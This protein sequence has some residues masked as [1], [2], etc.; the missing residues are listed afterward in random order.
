[1]YIPFLHH[2]CT[3]Y[4]SSRTRVQE[5]VVVV[6][7]RRVRQFEARTNM[8]VRTDVQSTKPHFKLQ[9]LCCVCIDRANLAKSMRNKRA[10]ARYIIQQPSY[11]HTLL[12]YYELVVLYSHPVRTP[13]Q[14][15][16]TPWF[17]RLNGMKSSST[18]GGRQPASSTTI[19][20]NNHH[21]NSSVAADNQHRSGT[22][23]SSSQTWLRL[24]SVYRVRFSCA[25][26]GKY[27]PS[28]KRKVIW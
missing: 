26:T 24:F 13:K 7:A 23:N 15:T 22:S 4:R 27:V 17:A 11:I 16:H 20:H 1:M 2:Y 8:A 5:E 12:Y 3:A 28:T 25:H 21:L 14:S 6:S 18:G 19:Q 10:R 9:L